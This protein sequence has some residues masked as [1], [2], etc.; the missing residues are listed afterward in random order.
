MI[1]PPLPIPTYDAYF[2]TKED[3]QAYGELCVKTI[4]GGKHNF[5][6]KKA[7]RDNLTGL[8]LQGIF[9]DKIP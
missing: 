1:L 9:I 5:R 3:M 4:C 2:Y 7:P 6:H 8:F